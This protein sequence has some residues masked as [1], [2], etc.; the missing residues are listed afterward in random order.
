MLGTHVKMSG[1]QH[2]MRATR[3]LSLTV[4][5][6][7]QEAISLALVDAFEPVEIWLLQLDRSDASVLENAAIFQ[8]KL[9]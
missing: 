5:A 3:N 1:C 4:T 9:A 2:S 8:S 7:R 6:P